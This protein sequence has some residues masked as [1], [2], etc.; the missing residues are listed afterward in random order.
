MKSSGLVL[1]GIVTTLNAD[2]TTRLQFVGN[3]SKSYQIEV[4]T[5]IV[6]WAPVGTCTADGDGNVEF[7]DLNAANQ[8]LRFYRAVEQ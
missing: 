7:T 2:G 5:D 3:N 4:S 8:P 1:E 6:N